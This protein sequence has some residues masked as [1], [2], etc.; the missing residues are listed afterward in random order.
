MLAMGINTGSVYVWD[1][2][3][4]TQLLRISGALPALTA[5]HAEPI[6][7]LNFSAPHTSFSDHLFVGC[8]DRTTTVHDVQAIR[9]QYHGHA[10]TALQ[11]HKG[12]ILDVQAGGDGRIVATWYAPPLTLARRMP[13]FAYGTWAHRPWRV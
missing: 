11:G 13:L 3:S 5:E 7:T 10:I 9:Q 8:D 4:R 6:R 12:W 2:A 1:M